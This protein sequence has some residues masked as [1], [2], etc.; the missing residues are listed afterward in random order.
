MR[1]EN[2]SAAVVCYACGGKGLAEAGTKWC[3]ACGGT[4]QLWRPSDESSGALVSQS[5]LF[6]GGKGVIVAEREE[7]F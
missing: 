4:G 2:V 6:C 1:R 5:C 7:Q 3:R